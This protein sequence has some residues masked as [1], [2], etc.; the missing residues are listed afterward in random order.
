MSEVTL[1]VVTH[2]MKSWNRDLSKCIQSVKD[3]LPSNSKHV[4]IEL[5][6]G[7]DYAG[8][9]ELRF[10]ALKLG[11]VIVF[12]DDDDYISK[13]SL[14]LCMQAL[15]SVKAG[16]AFTDEVRMGD[17]GIEKVNKY[18]ATYDMISIHPQVIHHMTA[19]RTCA[20]TDRAI[21]LAQK[22]ECGIEWIMKA[23]AALTMGA[24]Y[25]PI[26]G[27]YWVQHDAQYSKSTELQ[28]KY[29]SSMT[30]IGIELRTW[31]NKTGDIPTYKY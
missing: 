2:T 15:N 13:D 14:T 3:A 30:Q 6:D 19:I 24:I 27:Y 12:V 28:E 29:R 18:S 17:K 11:E 16:I 22:H 4:I 1:T 10:E 9:Q 25:V 7:L 23:E 5:D 26:N 31:G 8:F 21:K 20:V